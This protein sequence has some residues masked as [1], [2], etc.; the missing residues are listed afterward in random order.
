MRFTIAEVNIFIRASELT[1]CCT[2]Q[3][4]SQLCNYNFKT[5][6][7]EVG[8]VPWTIVDGPRFPYR[9]LLIGELL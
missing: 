6:L 1:T 4:F 7:L 5:R 3:T 9:G 8:W 2:F